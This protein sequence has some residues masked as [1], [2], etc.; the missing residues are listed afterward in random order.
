[1][2][3]FIFN[4][5]EKG[6]RTLHIQRVAKTARLIGVKGSAKA[7][8]KIAN[9]L[10]TNYSKLMDDAF[11]LKE[12]TGQKAIITKEELGDFFKQLIP[13]IKV[14]LFKIDDEMS[15]F[16]SGFLRQKMNKES[17]TIEGYEIH[18]RF[19]DNKDFY[20]KDD[21]EK[22]KTFKHEKKHLLRRITQPRYAVTKLL[23]NTTPEMKKN[24]WNFYKSVLYQDEV[25]NLAILSQ[26]SP[27]GPKLKIINSIKTKIDDILLRKQRKYLRQHP[28]ARIE[29]LEK[30]LENFF[31]GNKCS[32]EAK[33]EILQKWRYALKDE[34][35]ECTDGK[36]YCIEKEY[37]P[38]KLFKLLDGKSRIY[39]QPERTIDNKKIYFDPSGCTTTEEIMNKLNSFVDMVKNDSCKNISEH[40]YFFPQ[41]IKIIEQMLADEM[42][43]A[44]HD[45]KLWSTKTTSV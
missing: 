30:E 37:A 33:I 27:R 40:K 7:R 12:K 36:L 23:K 14:E 38:E 2:R 15:S 11:E 45:V 28:N 44:G 16:Y 26:S 17:G 22:I 39:Y 1:M 29:L 13:N 4:V 8:E 9:E 24:Q 3:G 6:I 43:K 32:S 25:K 18:T 5:V 31:K 21:F 19:T 35:A 41:K 10:Y 20:E 34:F 42:S